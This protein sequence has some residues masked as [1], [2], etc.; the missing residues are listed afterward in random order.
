MINNSIC[1]FCENP[2]NS[3]HLVFECG[4]TKKIWQY[5]LQWMNNNH[6]SL[7]WKK[8]LHWMTGQCNMKGQRME[9]LKCAFM[10]TIYEVWMF[11]I[12]SALVLI[13]AKIVTKLGPNQW[14]TLCRD[15][16]FTQNLCN[17]LVYSLCLR[18]DLEFCIGS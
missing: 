16:G 14:I 11:R 3:Q 5:V 13:A 6:L 18:L 15:V 7:G 17:K 9:I 2:E 8:E 10:E 4:I 12:F 1:C